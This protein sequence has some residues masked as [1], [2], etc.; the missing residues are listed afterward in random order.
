MEKSSNYRPDN[1]DITFAQ[2]ADEFLKNNNLAVAIELAEVGVRKYP[3]YSTGHLILARAYHQDNRMDE[4]QA[5]YE[6]VILYEPGNYRALMS[7][8]FISFKKRLKTLGNQY[9][10]QAV[11]YDFDN[12]ELIDY[13]KKENIY[14]PAFVFTPISAPEPER[15]PSATEESETVPVEIPEAVD[16]V[17]DPQKTIGQ[18]MSESGLVFQMAHEEQPVIEM[19]T[20]DQRVLEIVTQS[21]DS[22]LPIDETPVANDF[23]D[24]R[25]GSFQAE[26]DLSQFDNVRDDFST[27]MHGIFSE[28]E[29][30]KTAE[31]AEPVYDFPAEPESEAEERPLLDTS[32]IFLE[33]KQEAEKTGDLNRVRE[34][35]DIFIDNIHDESEPPEPP[36]AGV[37]TA[38]VKPEELR[39]KVRPALE[40]KN[41]KTEPVIEDLTGE[42]NGIDEILKNP[43][44]LTPTFG[45]ILIAQKKF[46]E[47]RQV[48]RKLSDQDPGNERLLRK[49]EFIDRMIALN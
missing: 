19:E 1:I 21:V 40:F 29:D 22:E 17:I 32:I 30:A 26:L 28:S 11:L 2:Q 8:A 7:L 48:F 16:V 38:P 46:S 31:N 36:K 34:E 45:E 9:L 5:E 47:A 43:K 24:P 4:A 44:L 10:Q 35:M 3:F 39:K 27:V 42:E 23:V 18:V 37:F 13:L 15:L 33:N 25:V 12:T 14:T 41:L 6:R 20:E 49:I